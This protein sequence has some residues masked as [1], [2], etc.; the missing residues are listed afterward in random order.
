MTEEEYLELKEYLKQGIK[1][2]EELRE[3]LPQCNQLKVPSFE[4]NLIS[5]IRLTDEELKIRDDEMHIMQQLVHQ[6]ID[7]EFAAE[8]L[9]TYR[10]DE[11]IK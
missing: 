6:E 4:Q 9:S 8:L 11:N 10:P 1:R 2:A 5:T 7:N 3:Q